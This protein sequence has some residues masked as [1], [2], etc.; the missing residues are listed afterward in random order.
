MALGVAFRAFFSALFNSAASQRIQQALDDRST[1]KAPA[2]PSGSSA[3]DL[4]PQQPPKP[5]KPTRNDALT[6]LSTLQREARLVD[7][8][9]EPLDQFSDQQI[10][11]A[12][13]EVLRDCKKTLDRMFAI[14]PLSDSEEGS[15]IDIPTSHSPAKLRL[16]GASSGQR[17]TVVHRGWKAT[18]CELPTWQGDKS[19]AMTIAPTEV[20]VG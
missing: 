19:D 16:I 18:A 13:R 2:L 4:K 10:G 3:A 8:V 15:K 12:A 14:Q 9:C 5:E 11:A 17:G 6:L 20:E 7:L 1:T